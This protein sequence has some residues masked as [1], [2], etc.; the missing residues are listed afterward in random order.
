MIYRY[1][2]KYYSKNFYINPEFCVAV[3]LFNGQETNYAEIK[4]G[5]IPILIDSTL[6]DL[7]EF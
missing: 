1:L 3:D 6:D 5:K 2:D 4:S 7:K